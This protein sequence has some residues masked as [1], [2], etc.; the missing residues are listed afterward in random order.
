MQQLARTVGTFIQKEWIFL[1]ILA[2]ALFCSLYKLTEAPATWYD[3]G[4][5]I[6]L[7][8][9][10]LHYGVM[11]TQYAPG[12]FV[13][14]AYTSTTFPV[15]VPI[16]LSFALFGVSLFSARIVMA[17]FIMAFLA[18][19]Y[20]LMKHVGGKRAALYGIALLATFSTLYGDGKNVLGEVP[21]MFYLYT[22]LIF[23]YRFFDLNKKTRTNAILMGLFLGLCLATKPTFLVLGGALIVGLLYAYFYK[24]ESFSLSLLAYAAIA[25]VIPV[26]IWLFTQFNTQDSLPSILSFYAN[27]YHLTGIASVMF[28]N[29]L[30]FFKESTPLYL[31]GML[32]VWVTSIGIRLYKRDKEV[33]VVEI[34][35]LS[36]VALI[37]FAYLRTPGWY[38]YFFTA[39]LIAILFF[40]FSLFDHAERFFV[41]ARLA[42]MR[43][44]ALPILLMCMIG[45][46]AYSVFS[47]SWVSTYY[48][49]HNTAQMESYFSTWSPG[50]TFF[51]YDI[52]ESVI[53]LPKGSSYYQYISGNVGSYWSIGKQSLPAITQ[54]IPDTIIVSAGTASTSELFPGYVLKDTVGK[55]EVLTRQ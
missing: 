27:P 8:I 49:S 50:H 5:I 17:G 22:G 4:M 26:L 46:Q 2:F 51:I 15:V 31:G 18:S 35:V 32:F 9:N 44:K 34:T 6:Q 48:N 45:A 1:L 53:F 12:M 25:A 33:S 41:S 24:K 47:G 42:W 7:A 10:L 20:Y 52:P 21:G 36:F 29:A 40:P 43:T 13:S 54:K 23:A 38:R 39:Q 55:I 16:A 19:G 14:G 28:H 11:G 3:E 30:R 37:L